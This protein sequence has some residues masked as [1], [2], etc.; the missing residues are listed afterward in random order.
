MR[1]QGPEGR[2][3]EEG[4]AGGGGEPR[5]VE[6]GPA[7][8]GCL[9]WKAAFGCLVT[10]CQSLARQSAG[11]RLLDVRTQRGDR[12]SH[13]AR[14]TA[15]PAA[16][17][18]GVRR[19]APCRV[20]GAREPVRRGAAC[21]P[22]P[23]HGDRPGAPGERR[24]HDRQGRRGGPDHGGSAPLSRDGRAQR[25]TQA[26]GAQEAQR[27]GDG[28]GPGRPAGATTAPGAAPG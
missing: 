21:P 26:A 19:G 9:G 15:G 1:P 23:G 18:R 25:W 28:R 13:P 5:G 20:R 27:R 14:P 16:G 2:R 10:G 8:G 7:A 6:A 11:Q 4:R 17:G 3:E 22:P 24:C 12:A